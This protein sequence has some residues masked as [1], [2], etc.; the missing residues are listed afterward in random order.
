MNLVFQTTD[1]DTCEE[2]TPESYVV[3]VF[4]LSVDE[5]SVLDVCDHYG[6]LTDEGRDIVRRIGVPVS[7]LWDAYQREKRVAFVVGGVFDIDNDG[8]VVLKVEHD[9]P[10]VGVYVRIGATV[11]R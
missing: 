5:A 6:T 11:T 1:T 2:V 10:A 9:D 8:G 3:D 4:A 7:A